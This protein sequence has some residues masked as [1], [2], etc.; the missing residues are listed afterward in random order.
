[1]KT[2]LLTPGTN[3]TF[4]A[5]QPIWTKPHQLGPPSDP[6]KTPYVDGKISH[7]NRGEA[8]A[9]SQSQDVFAEGNGVVRSNDTTKQNHGNA[10]GYVD[11]SALGGAAHADEDF[12]KAQCT[13][14]VLHGENESEPEPVEG[15]SVG[16]GGKT[17]MRQLGFPGEPEPGK[18]GYYIEILS[19][20]EVKLTATRRDKTKN[21][22]GDP[23]CWK[24]KTHTRW[25]AKR[26]GEGARDVAP[27]EGTDKYTVS[28][29][30]TSLLIGN[31]EHSVGSMTTAGR[32]EKEQVSKEHRGREGNKDLT[33]GHVK[34][35]EIEGAAESLE[36]VFAYFY[37]WARPV[38]VNVQ[39]TSCAG[40][41]NVQIRVFPRAKIAVV[42]NFSEAAETNLSA[43]SKGKSG[44]KALAAARATINKLRGIEVL[45]KKFAELSG[46]DN[47]EVE[48]CSEMRASFEVCFKPCT[49][50][51]TGFWGKLYTPA[52]CGM[53]W[54]VGLSTAVLVGIQ[55]EFTISL[56]EF[57]LPCL[58]TAAAWV[59]GEINVRADIVV[60]IVLHVP[61][62]V[63]IGADE[64]GN[65][66]KTGVTVSLTPKFSVFLR[67]SAGV[68]L[69]ST[70]VKFP[71]SLS[72]AFMV[73]DKPNYLMSFQPKGELR[74]IGFLKVFEDTW[75][76]NEWEKEWEAVRVNW[77]GPKYDMFKQS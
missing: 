64:Y 54:K 14:V 1:V 75:L 15:L 71:G 69:I 8:K 57:V 59:L 17:V 30:L 42:V 45:V 52:H 58:G 13:I 5:K 2:S 66:T 38:M 23:T 44:Q 51:K 77:I 6:D 3:K 53:P 9:T 19:N 31:E 48:F 7:T 28:K 37:Y 29:A 43:K 62:E 68:K 40:S 63:S 18:Q 41:R 67:I 65:W 27:V 74:T 24:N 55:V 11:G 35:V 61:L 56:V 60:Q 4:I 76:E 32:N 26:T 10:D 46:R 20:S 21:P 70:G 12:L 50:R 25:V 22:D 73:S 72:A 39:A 47:F 16:A 33:V 34:K 36:A 49:Q